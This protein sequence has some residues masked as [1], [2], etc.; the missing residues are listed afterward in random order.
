LAAIPVPPIDYTNLGYES[1]REA[2]LARARVTLPEWSDQSENDFGVMLVEQFAHAADITLYYQTRI[3][4]NLFPETADEPDAIVQL[5]RLIGYEL[6]PPSAATVDLRITFEPNVVAPFTIPAGSQF[7]A[8]TS[9][10]ETIPFET[11]RDVLVRD[12][13]LEPP[14]VNGI[15][16]RK[17]LVPLP[18]VQGETVAGEA[19]GTSDNTP[20]Q[21]YTLT[22]VPVIAGSVVVEMTEPGAVITR[23]EA[24]ETLTDSSPADRQFIVQR[25]AAG[26]AVMI[27]ACGPEG[28]LAATARTASKHS[29]PCQVSVE[30]IMGCGMGATASC[31]HWAAQSAPPTGSVAGRRAM[32]P[33]RR[34][35]PSFPSGRAR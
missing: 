23:W 8:T 15:D 19:L 12:A 24:E 3:A 22:R 32:S 31:H 33:R 34:S 20:N 2:M 30:R 28:M 14:A 4:S 27:Y 10:G 7:Q 6:S 5:L 21:R 9:A 11:E 13:D 35:S 26:A 29:R 16:P 1:L 18:A 25:D 17:Y